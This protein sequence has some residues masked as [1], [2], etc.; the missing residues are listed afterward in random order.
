MLSAPVG[1]QLNSISNTYS[2]PVDDNIEQGSVNSP[3]HMSE[4]DQP[5]NLSEEHE[6][7]VGLFRALNNGKILNFHELRIL[8]NFLF[9]CKNNLVN[10]GYL[11]LHGN[12]VLNE[13]ISK[14][15]R[16]VLSI[17]EKIIFSAYLQLNGESLPDDFSHLHQLKLLGKFLFDSVYNAETNP[18]EPVNQRLLQIEQ[19][20]DQGTLSESDRIIFIAFL[21]YTMDLMVENKDEAGQRSTMD[22]KNKILSLYRA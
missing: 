13:L 3:E 11:K 10:L 12:E 1:S 14:N 6:K 8:G 17:P 9:D 16:N 19:D 21:D 7:A 18:E 4:L 5:A 15:Q 2:S 22:D 20:M